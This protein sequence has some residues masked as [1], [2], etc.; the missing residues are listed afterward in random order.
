MRQVGH[1]FDFG[2][3]V[4]DVLE[5]VNH[6]PV[7]WMVVFPGGVK[8][9]LEV[10]HHRLHP[11][12]GDVAT[13]GH[14]ILFEHPLCQ[15]Q[16]VHNVFVL[17]GDLVRI[18]E[19]D[20]PEAAKGTAAHTDQQH[21]PNEDA[22]GHV[23]ADQDQR[24][25]CVD[26]EDGVVSL[27]S[28]DGG[29]EGVGA[30]VPEEGLLQQPSAV[31]PVELAHPCEYRDEQQGNAHDHRLCHVPLAL[32]DERQRRKTRVHEHH[33]ELDGKQNRAVVHPEEASLV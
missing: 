18:F 8:V 10:L 19:C 24:Q 17:H 14:A 22:D 26:E 7:E 3:E 4:G 1:R 28:F 31:T 23:D 20:G 13:V 33:D 11:V 5:H 15:L 29:D 16:V 2:V 27:D 6:G 21:Y 32:R 30:H 12:D 9:V 25:C